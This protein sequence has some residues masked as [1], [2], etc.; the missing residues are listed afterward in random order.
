MDS[1]T[2]GVLTT[3][4]FDIVGGLAILLGWLCLRRYRGDKKT[5]PR[6]FDDSEILFDENFE[7]N[8]LKNLLEEDI[9]KNEQKSP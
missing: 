4:G 7:K 9:E 5:V 3:F 1:N 6:S 8:L 2:L